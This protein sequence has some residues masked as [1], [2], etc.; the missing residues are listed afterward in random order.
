MIAKTPFRTTYPP[1]S[2]SLTAE[3][4]RNIDEIEVFRGV[5]GLPAP[6][7][8]LLLG[9]LALHG[10]AVQVVVVDPPVGADGV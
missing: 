2:V 9:T 3:E 10:G 8:G 6:A 1:P 4:G 5:H 7:G